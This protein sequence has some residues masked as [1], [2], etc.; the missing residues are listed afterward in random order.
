MTVI[1]EEYIQQIREFF[2]TYPSI[3]AV[4]VHGSILT[5]YFREDSDIDC[6]LL[7]HEHEA[8]SYVE[9]LTWAGELSD[10]TGRQ[11]DLG[12]LSSDNL[13]YAM[14]AISKGRLLFCRNKSETDRKV[15]H[16]YALYAT[17]REERAEVERAYGCG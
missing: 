6:A 11:I 15:M 2:L 14:Q 10:I 16:L 7:L 3:L 17:L 5:D 8:P 4:Y 12:I 1:Q 9:R 13:V